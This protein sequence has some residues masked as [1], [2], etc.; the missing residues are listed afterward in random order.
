MNGCRVRS[1]DIPNHWGMELSHR[2]VARAA[3]LSD[4][5]IWTKLAMCDL[6]FESEML[7]SPTSVRVPLSP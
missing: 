4:G 2:P 3:M 5:A 6:A 7:E 1:S